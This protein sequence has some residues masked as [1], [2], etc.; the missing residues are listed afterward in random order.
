MTGAKITDIVADALATPL[1]ATESVEVTNLAP[2]ALPFTKTF[3]YDRLVNFTG[4]TMYDATSNTAVVTSALTGPLA[5]VLVYSDPAGNVMPAAQG[6]AAVLRGR[7][8]R[9]R[10]RGDV[11]GQ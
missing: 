4:F 6:P 11:A 3:S 5:A 7:R 1:T 10:Q 8:R 2:P 9:R